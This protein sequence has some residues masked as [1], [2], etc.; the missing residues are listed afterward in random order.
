GIHGPTSIQSRE[1]SKFCPLRIRSRRHPR[2]WEEHRPL[3]A[4]HL[5]RLS[6]TW[7]IRGPS[8]VTTWIGEKTK[9][10]LKTSLAS[11]I[12]CPYESQS[13]P[14]STN[15]LELRSASRASSGLD[16]DL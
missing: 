13:L 12:I 14:L 16:R 4:F 10:P 1:H 2:R 3:P 8:L 15:R 6:S 9:W 11:S 5:V 7:R